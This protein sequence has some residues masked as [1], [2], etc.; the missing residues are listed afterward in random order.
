[1][2][3]PTKKC[4]KLPEMHKNGY[5]P[6]KKCLKI[7]KYSECSETHFA[8]LVLS[9]SIIIANHNTNLSTCRY[10]FFLF[11][12]T[13]SEF[14]EDNTQMTDYYDDFLSEETHM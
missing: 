3:Y 8:T 13:N 1:M 2:T 5:P 14:T 9:P 4:V 10:N 6:K 11:V 7:Y 12:P